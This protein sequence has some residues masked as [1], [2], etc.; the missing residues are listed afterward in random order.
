MDDSRNNDQSRKV[1]WVK[2]DALHPAN[3]GGRIRT[4][5]ML[6][7]WS[8]RH[9]IDYLCLLPLTASG[10]NTDQ[11]GEYSQRQFWVN[12]RELPRSGLRFLIAIGRNFLFSRY[13]FVIDKYVS[14][15]ARRVLDLRLTKE[16]YDLVV[17]D[18]PFMY[19]NLP[20]QLSQVPRKVI[21]QHN[22]ESQIWKRHWQN[23]K[24]PLLRWYL[25]K[26]YQR[27]ALLEKEICDR[28]DGVITVS[29]DDSGIFREQLGV[30]N[31]LGDVPAGV[32]TDYFSPPAARS[33]NHQMVFVGSMDWMPNV[34]AVEFFVREI[35][36]G[37]RE[38]VG[39]AQFIVV[40]RNP[41]PRVLALQGAPGLTITG[42]VDDVRPYVG[43][44]AISVVPLRIAG[45]T[46]IKIY[47]CMAL[48]TPVVS[49]TVG[50]EGLPVTDGEHLLIA[51]DAQ[52]WVTTL[53]S[54]LADQP[55]QQAIGAAGHGL[56][57]AQ[58]SWANAVEKFDRLCFDQQTTNH[59]DR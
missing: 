21:F 19:R 28:F 16:A 44:A 32:D 43:G 42:T 56:V 4:L 39:D 22:V 58:F 33:S 37:V 29:E 55:R 18:F 48:A 7:V 46:R 12:W 52:A 45:G 47:E 31:V 53:V 17:C 9:Q 11:A 6:K 57:N 49:T 38:Q 36:P 41:S 20:D 1:L 50:A 24:N 5:N 40:G 35:L 30:T 2:T 27:F 54:L 23:A 14:A 59:K 3:S 34:D 26:Q 10:E 25:K 13:P 51:D 8:G 15:A